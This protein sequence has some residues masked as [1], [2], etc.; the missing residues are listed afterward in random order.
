MT[1]QFCF[2]LYFTQILLATK[3]LA[4]H[5]R[6]TFSNIYQY[7]KINDWQCFFYQENRCLLLVMLSTEA[8][9]MRNM[10]G[11]WQFRQLTYIHTT[12]WNC[13]GMSQPSTKN[14]SWAWQYHTHPAKQPF[15]Y[16]QHRSYRCHKQIQPKLYDGSSK[17]RIQ[18]F[19]KLNGNLLFWQQYWKCL[20]T[21]IYGIC[22][23]TMKKYLGQSLYFATFCFHSEIKALA[24]RETEKILLPTA[25]IAT[26]LGYGIWFII[27]AS[28]AFTLRSTAWT[29]QYMLNNFRL[30]NTADK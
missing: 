1:R 13:C 24:V 15:R 3:V 23:Q 7:F 14:C 25:E 9:K 21:S 18:L 20:G 29:K 28:S 16:I 22:H 11:S 6:R 17:A 30:L 8:K 26:N 5:S 2:L 19:R 10:V 4:M 27:A 12:M